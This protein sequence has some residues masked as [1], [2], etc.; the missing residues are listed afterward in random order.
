M[1]TV[2]ISLCRSDATMDMH[3][4]D[5]R[6]AGVDRVLMDVLEIFD[7]AAERQEIPQDS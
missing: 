5:F 7:D 2:P 1:L 3:I 6:A 4:A